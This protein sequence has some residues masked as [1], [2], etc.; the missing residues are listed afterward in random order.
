M[1]RFFTLLLAASCLTAVGQVDFPYNPDGNIDGLVGVQDLQDFLSI[2]GQE[3]QIVDSS[4]YWSSQVNGA[5]C[6]IYYN[7]N[8]HHWYDPELDFHYDIPS[9]CTFVH[10]TTN[11][12]Y[13]S[14]GQITARNLRL[15]TNDLVVGQ[16]INFIF[17]PNGEPIYEN[18]NNGWN[19]AGKIEIM[20]YHNDAWVEVGAL[21]DTNCDSGS[22]HAD[23]YLDPATNEKFMWTG[24]YWLHLET[25][26]QL[27][28]ASPND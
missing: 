22:C 9:T 17:H 5:S 26:V 6:F 11:Y 24:E 15:P 2:Y 7:Y 12:Y 14:Y 28:Q 27:I 10:L 25:P 3:F 13:S 20:A 19:Y 16:V 18:G 8:G 23:Y 4:D 1:N 21:F